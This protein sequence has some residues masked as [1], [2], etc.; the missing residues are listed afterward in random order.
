MAPDRQLSSEAATPS[1]EP[2]AAGLASAGEPSDPTEPAPETGEM[3]LP[4]HARNR[5]AEIVRQSEET[6]A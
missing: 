6:A 1:E 5:A 4:R 3:E 2:P